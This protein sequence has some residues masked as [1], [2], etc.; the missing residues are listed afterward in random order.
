M[1][2]LKE[3][4]N[5]EDYLTSDFRYDLFDGW[6]LNAENILKNQEDID[7]INNAIKVIE[8]Y[9][10]IREDNDLYI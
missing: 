10:Q 6:Y 1:L 2:E 5:L 7:K 4:I 8:E 9:R 3:W